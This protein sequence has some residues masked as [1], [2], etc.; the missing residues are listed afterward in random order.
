MST[1]N[2]TNDYKTPPSNP[3]T[4]GYKT[5]KFR[6]AQ[7]PANE[8]PHS[9]SSGTSLLFS[10]E[11]AA[12]L[13]DDS[14][15]DSPEVVVTNVQISID[16]IANAT[17]ADV[18]YTVD[19]INPHKRIRIDPK[20]PK[21]RNEKDYTRLVSIDSITSSELKK[22]D[23]RRFATRMGIDKQGKA[24]K[25]AICE[26]I[27]Q[28]K[29][30]PKK[31]EAPKKNS[32]ANFKRFINAL[33]SEDFA[34]KLATRGQ[35]L[36]KDQMTDGIK[37]DELLFRDFIV[38]YNNKERFNDDEY[39]ELQVKGD[40]SSFDPITSWMDARTFF[41]KLMKDYETCLVNWKKSG[42][43]GAFDDT[44]SLPFKDF[45]KNRGDMLYL[46]E[47]AHSTPEVLNKCISQ[48]NADAFY[49]SISSDEEE[50]SPVGS[51][52]AKLATSSKKRKQ[53]TRRSSSSGAAVATAILAI[54]NNAKARNKTQKYAFLIESK[55]TVIDTI[56]DCRK[57]KRKALVQGGEDR[58]VSLSEMKKGF[59]EYKNKREGTL[60]EVEERL[61]SQDSVFEVV[62]EFDADIAASNE[63]KASIQ[64]KLA[65]AREEE[66]KE[67][68]LANGS[69]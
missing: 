58:G 15:D 20:K 12:A 52:L 21:P 46:H 7:K 49:E 1:N 31:K 60:T 5:G 44:Q 69:D 61:L 30:K 45:R 51:E 57:E 18:E 32:R 13:A 64:L 16:P 27:V 2:T 65:K 68:S 3:G 23:I 41:R 10:K 25:R 47:F 43:H 24:G 26:A 53:S 67:N 54:S 28:H 9:S 35:S 66:D 62:M 55:K 38:L 14:D 59:E 42:N 56:A 48:L 8:N 50:G 6:V 17:M 36:T 40:P 11:E 19:F 37:T 29:I 33:F 34:P 63:E 22:D 4:V 39:P